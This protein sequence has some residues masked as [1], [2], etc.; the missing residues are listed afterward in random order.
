LNEGVT[1]FK[2]S[3]AAAASA[4][5]LKARTWYFCANFNALSVE[6]S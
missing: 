4:V 2:A 1:M 3:A 6:T 5:V